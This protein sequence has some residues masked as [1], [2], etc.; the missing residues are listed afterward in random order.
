MP[1]RTNSIPVYLVTGFLGSGKTTL[2]RR[3]AAENPHRRIVFLVNELADADVD[4]EALADLGRPT[5]A[6]VGGSVF[7]ECKAGDF[8]RVMA[9]EVLPLRESD[10]I[11]AVVLETSGTADPDAIGT[12]FRGHGLENSF[13]VR[14]IV[15]VV[16]PGRFETLL[17]N[18]PV[19]ESQIRSS[20]L[21]IVNKV[22]LCDDATVD[23]AA[24][25]VAEVNPRAR[26]ERATRCRVRFDWFERAAP[27]P[28]K[29]LF[30]CEANP[31]TSVTVQ[32]EGVVPE[33]ILADWLR[34]LPDFVYRA[35]G[36][37]ETENGPRRVER[38]VDSA[39]VEPGG[40]GGGSSRLVLI[41]PD[42]HEDDL[43]AVIASLD[44][45]RGTP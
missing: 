6:V 18:L 38:T 30:P 16:S 11:D 22:D 26:I 37:V 2:L 5:H 15:S 45:A 42:E 9:E 40:D 12:L 7:C 41:V 28:G 8:L 20:D 21:I 13:G 31:F 27:L 10:G 19:I 39:T 32:P 24:K 35:K 34:G 4:G 23:R 1:A 33:G 14:G 43:G 3:L 36:V 44:A 17:E 25:R 29:D